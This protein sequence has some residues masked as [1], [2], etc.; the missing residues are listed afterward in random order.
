MTTKIAIVFSVLFLLVSCGKHEARHFLDSTPSGAGVWTELD[1]LVGNTP[2]PVPVGGKYI[3][4]H[5]GCQ[6]MPLEISE[7]KPL[8]FV[9]DGKRF[10]ATVN[11]KPVPMAS[12]TILCESTPTGAEVFLDGESKGNTPLELRGLAPRNYELTFKKADREMVVEHVEWKAEETVRSVHVKLPSTMVVFYRNK[13]QSEPNNLLHYADLG[14]HLAQDGE[15]QTAVNVYKTG[16]R[17]VMGKKSSENAYR[18][19]AEVDRLVTVQY[20]Y[21]DEAAIRQ[22]R[23]LVIEM[24]RELFDEYPNS[25]VMAFY[26]SYID[27]ADTLKRRNEAQRIFSLAYKKWPQEKRMANY[28]KRGF[29]P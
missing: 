28:I 6:D 11:L 9:E 21:G 4:R 10:V 26:F 2:M 22:A 5:P 20:V 13:L 8:S 12:C 16:L 19:W 23:Q 29:V 3:L 17:L 14:H 18:L 1:E 25:D 7:A 27:C 15:L 24:L